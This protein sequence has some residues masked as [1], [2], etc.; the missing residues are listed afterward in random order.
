MQ[1]NNKLLIVGNSGDTQVGTH[2]RN[3][4]CKLHVPVHYVD[5]KDAFS[6][7]VLLRQ[8]NWW[9]LGHRPYHL[10]PFSRK[11]LSVCKS[12]QP[13]WLLCTGRSPILSEV[14]IEIGRLGIQRLNYLTDDPWNPSHKASWLFKSLPNYDMIFSTRKTNIEDL[15]KLG[16]KNVQFLPF[17]YSPEIHFFDC[18]ASSTDRLRFESDV[19]F[20]GAADKDRIPY[21]KALIRGGLKIGLYGGYWNRYPEVRKFN[22]GYANSRDLRWA[23]STTKLA[24][25]L[26]RR[27]N[28]DDNSMRTFEIPAIGTCMLAEDTDE[29]RRIFAE[30]G[31]NVLYFKDCNEML[32][33]TFFLLN[34][35]AERF[36]LAKA[37]H[38]L[39]IRGHH[40]YKD[41]LL[42]ILEMQD[43]E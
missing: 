7:S 29:H 33:K 28:R 10:I 35:N 2:F 26:V 5:Q 25:G 17:A 19:L 30:D 13:R 8:I 38:E 3:A 22:R 15:K 39:I 37:A 27:A 40:T 14:L 21:I 36:R 4:A 42:K 31:K 41:R 6:G 24:L 23:L 20:I 16:C 32:Q 43:P 34:N 18:P 11:V 1:D 12:I 9:L